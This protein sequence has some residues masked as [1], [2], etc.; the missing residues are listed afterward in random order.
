MCCEEL[1]KV[2]ERIADI[3][4][5]AYLKFRELTWDAN[6][7]QI[8]VKTDEIITHDGPLTSELFPKFPDHLV[9]NKS[10][11]QGILCHLVCQDAFAFM[12]G[13]ISELLQGS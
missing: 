6:V 5:T 13:L 9:P 7:T 12:K 3:I 8:R 10:V 11:K 1:E 2:L 4:Q